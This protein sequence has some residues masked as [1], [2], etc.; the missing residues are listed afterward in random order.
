V[1]AIVEEHLVWCDFVCVYIEEAHAKDEW[2]ISR[3][4]PSLRF[5]QHTTVE[6]RAVAALK[7]AAA[8]EVHPAIRIYVD[9]FG[10]GICDRS[11]RKCSPAG[12]FNATFPSWP[13]RW[14]TFDNIDDIIVDKAMPTDAIYD[15]RDLDTNLRTLR[16]RKKK[17][18]E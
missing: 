12:S 7:F 11:A 13:F 3:L 8:F 18:N 9:S 17:E 10:D 5:A 2:P 1:N 4:P 15:C 6:Q 14:W 16:E